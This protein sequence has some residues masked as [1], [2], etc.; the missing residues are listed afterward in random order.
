MDYVLLL[1]VKGNLK[2]RIEK[3]GTEIRQDDLNPAQKVLRKIAE[4]Q[5]FNSVPPER[6]AWAN[7]AFLFL[8]KAHADQIRGQV[9]RQGVHLQSKHILVSPTHRQ[10]LDACLSAKPERSGREAFLVSRAGMVQ[11]ETRFM[12]LPPW[13]PARFFGPA[14]A[15]LPQR[16]P[17]AKAAATSGQSSGNQRQPLAFLKQLDLDVVMEFKSVHVGDDIMDEDQKQ[18]TLTFVTAQVTVQE[19]EIK[20]WENEDDEQDNPRENI[21]RLWDLACFENDF[22]QMRKT[23]DLL[24]RYPFCTACGKRAEANHLNKRAHRNQ[25]V[26]SKRAAGATGK[27]EAHGPLLIEM[28]CKEVPAGS[29]VARIFQRTTVLTCS[30]EGCELPAGGRL[31]GSKRY[32]C[33]RCEAAGLKGG[34]RKHDCTCTHNFFPRVIYQ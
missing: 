18:D 23:K 13:P 2:H 3:M 26:S 34:P 22:L 4:D 21:V 7:G 31:A 10:A 32:C 27:V 25:V 1:V 16:Q 17:V 11:T 29:D 6:P 24:S 8:T 28:L 14:P 33:T 30:T 19:L 20:V 5:G 15:P 9:A 12:L